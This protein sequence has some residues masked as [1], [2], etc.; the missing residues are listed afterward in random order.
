V[1]ETGL[2]IDKDDE[3]RRKQLG[4]SFKRLNGMLT[5]MSKYYCSEMCIE[6]PTTPFRCWAARD[7]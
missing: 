6:S 3:K 4:R 2:C 5:P 7:T 1:L